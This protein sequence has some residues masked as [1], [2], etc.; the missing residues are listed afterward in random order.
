MCMGMCMKAYCTFLVVIFKNISKPSSSRLCS[1][2]HP[3]T[4]EEVLEE[5]CRGFGPISS[6]K[7]M[8]PRTEEER[9]RGKNTGFVSF[10]SRHDAC[11]ALEDLQ[12]LV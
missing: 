3:S 1:N 4:T 7:I 9:R 8:W 2:L 12:D 6:V 5:L 11:R 10:Q